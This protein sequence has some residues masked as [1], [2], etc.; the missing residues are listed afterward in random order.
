MQLYHLHTIKLPLINIVDVALQH[1]F[2]ILET[3]VKFVNR[4][5]SNLTEEHSLVKR[6]S[7]KPVADRSMFDMYIPDQV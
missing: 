3:Q 5:K 6:V 4:K 2:Y 1:P 7:F